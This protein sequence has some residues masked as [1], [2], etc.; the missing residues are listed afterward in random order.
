[1]AARPKAESL[2][3]SWVRIPWGHGCLS[4]VSACVVVRY[5]SLRRAD[6]LTRGVLPSVMCLS[7]TYKSLKGGSVGP[8]W[9]AAPQERKSKS[10]QQTAAVPVNSNNRLLFIM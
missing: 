3:G 10:S 2:L 9:A 4:V 1:V 5:R 7:V 8:I 6:H